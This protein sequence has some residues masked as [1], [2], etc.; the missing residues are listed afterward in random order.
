MMEER[1]EIKKLRDEFIAALP[2]VLPRPSRSR[3]P[4][5]A[6]STPSFLTSTS[7]TRSTSRPKPRSR[8]PPSAPRRSPTTASTLGSCA[9]SPPSCPCL[10]R[11]S[12]GCRRGS[13]WTCIGTTRPRSRRSCRSAGRSS[14]R[15][16]TTT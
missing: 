13:W 2:K 7:G 12:T 10:R 15:G 8:V 4:S 11:S 14:T 6:R 1:P 5:E 3:R 16:W 9:P